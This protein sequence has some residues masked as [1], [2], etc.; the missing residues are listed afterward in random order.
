M[1]ANEDNCKIGEAE[2]YM[3]RRIFIQVWIEMFDCNFEKMH[4]LW[5]L[6]GNVSLSHLCV[7]FIRL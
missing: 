5:P 3:D 7:T 1:P 2:I 6:K 4:E